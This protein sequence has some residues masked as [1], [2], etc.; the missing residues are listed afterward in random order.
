MLTIRKENFRDDEINVILDGLV[1]EN[2]L[3][4]K[5][6]NAIDFSFIYDKVK[7]LY[8][9]LGAP[10]IDPVVL[11]KIVLIQYLFGIPSMRQTIREIEVNVAYR[12]FL[13]YSLTEKIPH[14]STFNKNYERRFKNTDLFESIFKEIL[15][16]A[17]KCGF[18]DSS[19]IYID[20]THIKA[21][22]N[23]KKYT[24]VEVDIQAKHYQEKLE[25][26]INEDRLKHGKSPLCEVKNEEV[27]KK[28]KI[29]S[30]TDK[31]S[32][33]FFKNEKEKCFAYLA[34][35]ACDNNNFILDFHIT[36]GN[37]HDSVAFSDLYQKIKNNS[38]QH[39][40]AIAIDAGYITPYICKTI[41]D[42][43][44]IPAIPYKRPLTKKGFFKKYDYVYDEYYDCYICPNNK[45]LKYSTTNRDGYRE[46][47][48]NPSDCK[49]CE[50]LNICTNSKNK[51]KLVTRHIW[52][53]YLEEADHLR[54][55]PY[56]KKVY[57]KRKETI[58]RV[59]ADAKEKHGMRYT[60]LR[61]LSK[62]EMEVSLIFSC[63][64]LKKLAKFDITKKFLGVFCGKKSVIADKNNTDKVCHIYVYGFMHN[65]GATHF[66]LCFASFLKRKKRNVICIRHN[67]TSDYRAVTDKG[68]LCNGI[69]TIGADKIKGKAGIDIIPDYNGCITYN[70]SGYEYIIHDCGCIDEHCIH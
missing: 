12:W 39:T 49:S 25:K 69:Y 62:I 38:K 7:D 43:G 59:F 60:K 23:K 50:H 22:A 46:Y 18:V 14:F 24:K 37:I 31:D 54:H 48:S 32:G 57:S 19:N 20:S 52:Q 70:L 13:G 41:L 65:S 45:I 47:K 3:V 44:I 35:T 55:K 30:N 63:M 34:H 4:R 27:K 9:P 58:E 42:D 28:E 51:Q 64:N 36:S 10:S 56:V 68:T 29:E 66:C 15:A 2:H 8:S 26:E 6:E 17:T 21:S 67:D 61:G 16:R 40:T 53:N 5:I 33:M 11:I 1:P